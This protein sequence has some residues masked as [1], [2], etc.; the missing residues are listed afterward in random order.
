MG[1]KFQFVTLAGLH[2]LNHSMFQ[3]TQGC[4]DRGMT[5]YAVLQEAEIRRGTRWLLGDETP[6][7]SRHRLLRSRRPNYRRWQ[8]LDHGVGWLDRSGAVPLNASSTIASKNVAQDSSALTDSRLAARCAEIALQAFFD[9]Q[10][11]F[12]AITR[13]ARE[14]FFDTRLG[15]QFR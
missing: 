11:R 10:T 4:R 13:R 9:Y 8:K 15:R 6:A 3:L 12:N 2:A 7:R 14:R 1:Y 5:A